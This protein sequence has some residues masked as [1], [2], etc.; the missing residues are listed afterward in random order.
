MTVIDNQ[1]TF[2][3]TS[4]GFSGLVGDIGGTNARFAIAERKGNIYGLSHIKAFETGDYPDLYTVIADYF[5]DIG[6][7]PSLDFAACAIAG[8]VVD[9]AIKFTNLDWLVTETEL[10]ARTG[11][12][13]ARL[14][15]DYAALAFSL[16]HLTE[17]DCK[18]IGPVTRGKGHVHAVMGAGTGFGASVLV[19]GAFGPYCLSTE[20]G[21]ASW[22]PV[23]DFEVE[24]HKILRKQYGRVTIEM[25]LSG[26][27]LV[28]LYQAITTAR[29]EPTL[30]LTPAEITHLEGEDAQGSRYTVEVFLDILASV[31]GDL[32]LYQGATS[33]IFIAGGI[34]PR[35][36]PHIDE[37]RFRARLEA[38]AP[39]TA[40]VETIPSRIITHPY[41]ALVGAAN[42][43]TE[44]EITA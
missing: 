28:N 20:S 2:S 7:K 4:Q 5:S 29:G 23:N 11:A 35:L 31:A 34:A 22:A 16:P 42:A 44:A 43:L 26:P 25:L 27:G 3:G 13:K 38:K 12:R 30:N 21:H 24:I 10:K 8:P 9:G 6:G 15:N 32:A 33:G 36:I 19:G 40:L 41:A 14:L 39:M 18:T 17:T 37:A 1:A